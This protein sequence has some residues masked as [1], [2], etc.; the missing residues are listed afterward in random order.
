MSTKVFNDDAAVLRSLL[1]VGVNL[2]VVPDQRT[3]LDM[4][5]AEARKLTGAEAGTLYV[6]Y[7]ESLR[8]VAVQNDKADPTRLTRVLVDKE[9]PL[10]GDSIAAFAAKTGRIMNIPNTSELDEGCPFRINR[11][12]DA[13]VGYQVRTL[14]AI[15]LTCPDGQCVGVLQ[16]LNHLDSERQVTPFPS[17][18]TSG[19]APLASMAAVTIHNS[20]LQRALKDAQLDCIIRLAVAAE[21]RDDD[22]AD[23]VRR[24]S[25]TSTLVAEALGMTGEQV[26]LIQHASPMHDIGKIGIPDAILRKPGPLTFEERNIVEK[27]TII[28]ADIL[29]D[30]PNDLIRTARDVALSHHERWDGKGYPNGLSAEDIPLCGR[31]VSLADVF[32]ALVSKR[33][34]KEAFALEIALEIIR[35]EDGK[36]FDPTVASAF[37]SVMSEVLAIY[38]ELPDE[39]RADEAE[40]A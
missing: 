35:F 3:M 13:S 10:D 12:F 37:F 31:I 6:V 39:Q 40:Q 29:G 18:E 34:Y 33:C 8:F 24:I 15:P 16:L 20:L 22:T 9:V 7:G 17:E 36:H 2:S 28:G 11:D 25:K 38:G 32:D 27:H 30:P 1:E 5:L 26:E 14:L 23:H 4:I 21:F 19:I